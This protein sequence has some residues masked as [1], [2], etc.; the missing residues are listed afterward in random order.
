MADEKYLACDKALFDEKWGEYI[1]GEHG[2]TIYSGTLCEDCD[3]YI[4]RKDS[5]PKI[6]K[7]RVGC[8]A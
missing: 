4:K 1:C 8:N 5:E 7:G 6:A 3:K 2:H